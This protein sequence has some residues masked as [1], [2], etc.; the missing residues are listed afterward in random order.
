MASND[1]LLQPYQLKQLTLRNRI[2]S[3]AHE[4]SYAEGGMPTDRY[5]LYHVERAKGGIALTMT[6][7]SAV[8]AEDS[9]PSFGNL[10]AYDD[11]IVTWLR[12]LTDECHE[13]GAAVMIQLTHL[14][15]RTGWNSGDWLP[16]LAPSPVREPAHR[17]FPKEAEDWDLDRIVSKYADAAERMQAGGMDGIELEAYGHFLDGFWSPATNQRNDEHN[18]SLDNR[19]RFTLRVL[20]AIRAAVGPEFIIGMRMVADEDWQKGLSRAEGVAIAKMLVATGLIDFLNIIRGHI[21]TDAALSKVI[22]TQGTVSAPHLDF[23]G[24][25]RHA[26]RFPVFHAARISDVATARHAIAEGK[27]DM[28]GMTRAHIADPHIALKVSQGREHDIR[29]CVGATYCLDRIYAGHEALCIHNPATG[30][31]RS[32]P[33][34]IEKSRGTRRKVVVVGA[35]PGGLEAARVSAERGHEVVLFEA[36]SNAGGQISLAARSHR[37]AELSGIVE[38][39]VGRCQAHGVDMRFNTLADA[40]TVRAEQP[41][42]VI[43]ATG[44]LPDTGCLESGQELVISSWDILS[45]TVKPADNVLLYDDNGAHPGMQA[46][47]RIAEGGATL[48]IVTPERFFAPE[49]GGINHVAYARTFQEHGVRITINRRVSGVAVS[50]NQLL[51]T[52]GSDYTDSGDERLVDQVV[53]EHG[54]LPQEDLYFALKQ[55][56]LNRGAVDY[57]ALITGRAQGLRGNEKGE[58]Q[59]FR[60]GDAISSRD[61][62]AAI[63]DAIRLCKDL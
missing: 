44:G 8:V 42:V 5:R 10:H 24:E 50:G 12:R 61:V 27:L 54:T 14:G 15:R 55:G 53:I 51:V 49:I 1:P 17:A 45:G 30:R 28:V 36:A 6:A 19:L 22:P 56:S 34:V 25:V 16:V 20:E 7:G 47:E 52:L 43:I 63:Y 18:G 41:D 58:Y 60:I 59:L 37:R 21:D 57:G 29:P 13:H 38:W 39:R 4:P 32:I 11:A 3:T 31:E 40:S 46:A 9:P 62:H 33:H 2:M 26:T 23:A 35:G 48:E